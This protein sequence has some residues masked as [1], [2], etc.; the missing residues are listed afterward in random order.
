VDIPGVH[1]SERDASQLPRWRQ[2]SS[3]T[4][5]ATPTASCFID[6]ARVALAPMLF[7]PRRIEHTLDV[8]VQRS[9]HTYPGEHRWPVMLRNQQER[10][11]RGLPFFGIVVCLGELGD[12]M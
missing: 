7:L 11:H 12:V 4:H 2:R 8:T 1:P 9:H 5:A 10:L 3:L 6:R